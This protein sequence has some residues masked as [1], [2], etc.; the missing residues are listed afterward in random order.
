MIH[1]VVMAK[2][3]PD[4]IQQS[5]HFIIERMV[6]KDGLKDELEDLKQELKRDIH[7]VE[8]KL[9]GFENSEIDKRKQLEVRVAKLENKVFSS[10]RS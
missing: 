8:S 7:R 2:K 4:G 6:T 3:K 1:F 10:R 5:L 9:A